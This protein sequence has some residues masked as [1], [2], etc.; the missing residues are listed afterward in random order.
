LNQQITER[1]TTTKISLII[2]SSDY[3]CYSFEAALVLSHN[4][5]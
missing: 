4:K 2:T 1:R 5:F 3:Y